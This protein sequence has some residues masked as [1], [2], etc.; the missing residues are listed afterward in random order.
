MYVVQWLELFNEYSNKHV[1]EWLY[2]AEKQVCSQA[3]VLHSILQL[4]FNWRFS[5][6]TEQ[7]AVAFPIE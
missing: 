6:H 5:S 3:P 1:L 7:L 2:V 4:K